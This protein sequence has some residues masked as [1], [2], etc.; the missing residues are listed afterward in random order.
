MTNPNAKDDVTFFAR[1][2]RD[3]AIDGLSDEIKPTEKSKWAGEIWY[4]NCCYRYYHLWYKGRPPWGNWT[5]FYE[6][7]MRFD[8]P[9]EDMTSCSNAHVAI[10]YYK[11]HGKIDGLSVDDS[12]SLQSLVDNLD[13]HEDQ[14]TDE[15]KRIKQRNRWRRVEVNF[16]SNILNDEFADALADTLRRFIEVATPKIMD[17]LDERDTIEIIS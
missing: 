13:I 7:E 10:R 2:V 9:S 14:R 3:L 8:D 11:E 4:K 15:D 17:F 5:L 1:R 16:G 6:V 12:K